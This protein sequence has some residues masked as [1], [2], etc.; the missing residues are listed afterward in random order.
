MTERRLQPPSTLCMG[1]AGSGKTSA[2]VTYIEAG[3][4][5]FVIGTEPNCADSLLDALER[6]KLPIEKLHWHQVTPV[7]QNWSAINAM[8][9]TVNAM[10]YE[11]ITKLKQGIGKTEQK[12]FKEFLDTVQNFK[13]DRDGK[14]YG[15][16][17]LWGDDRAFA[18]DSLSGMSYMSMANTVGLKP[19]IHQGEWGVA[20][21]VI[22]QV[23]LK[24]T[25]DCKCFFTLNAHTEKE[26]DQLGGGTKVMVST[27]GAKLAPKI[28]KFFSEVVWAKK[29]LATPQFT[30]S[31]IDNDAD[32]KNRALPNSATLDPSYV[33]IVAVHR[34]RKLTMSGSPTVGLPPASPTQASSSLLATQ[35]NPS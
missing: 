29:R 2:L 19:A 33:Q 23:L 22:D 4:E 14:S 6:K 10:S 35:G 9:T 21:N 30:W 3:L 31:T 12:A 11:D 13:C 20:M 17:T 26:V 34:K 5:L 18:I 15:D 25:S 8:L 16:A 32:L 1:A 27:L 7:A 28:P 24:I